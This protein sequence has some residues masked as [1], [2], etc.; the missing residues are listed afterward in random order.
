MIDTLVGHFLE[1]FNESVRVRQSKKPKFYLFDT[2]IQRSL[3]QMVSTQLV[4]GSSEYGDLFEQWIVCECIRLNDYFEKDFRF[5][6]LRTKDNAEIDLIVQKPGKKR[7]LIEIKSTDNVL[8]K[9]WGNLERLS[10]DITH[11]EKW[12]LCNES[13]T[14]ITKEGIHIMPWRLGLQKLFT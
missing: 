8:P 3:T 1:P 9:H 7:I 14:R 10:K 11:Q 6:Y 13:Q 5:Y 4:K 2:G 12:I